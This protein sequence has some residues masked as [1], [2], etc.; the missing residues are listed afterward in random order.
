MTD[1]TNMALK[2]HGIGGRSWSTRMVPQAGHSPSSPRSSSSTKVSHSSHQATRRLRPSLAADAHPQLHRGGAE[3]ELF[4]QSTLD[5]AQVRLGQSPIGEKGKGGRVNGALDDVA[6]LGAGGGLAQL[7][8]ENGPVEGTS[9][10]PLVIRLDRVTQGREDTV[11]AP[12]RKGGKFQDRGGTQEGQAIT[13][14]EQDIVTVIGRHQIPLVE[15]DDGRAARYTDAFG[16][17]LVLMG[18]TAGGVDHQDGDVGPFQRPQRAKDGMVLGAAFGPGRTA[19]AG[20][21]DEADG[22]VSRF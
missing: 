11:H 9:G 13:H 4:A 16:Q 17:S 5:V 15:D 19:E 20:G 3:F 6:N 12:A 1:A 22:A 10:H 21:I 2:Y 18:R 7:Q 14:A 8:F